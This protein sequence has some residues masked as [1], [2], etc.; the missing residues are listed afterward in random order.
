MS[1]QQTECKIDFFFFTLLL[2]NYQTKRKSNKTPYNLQEPILNAEG[3]PGQFRL[4]CACGEHVYH[5]LET[6]TLH[7]SGAQ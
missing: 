7:S 2:R 4:Q 1:G 3:L 6:V 5:K